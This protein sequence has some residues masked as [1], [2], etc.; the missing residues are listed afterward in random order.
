MAF[1]DTEYYATRLLN[2]FQG[3]VHIISTGEA[4]AESTDGINWR[5]KIRSG[6][7]KTP[8]TS[9]LHPGQSSCDF[10]YGVWSHAEGLKRVPV[11]P[12][13]YQEHVEQAVTDLLAQLATAAEKL[14]FPFRDIVECWMMDTTGK[15]PIVLLASQPAGEA[16]PASQKLNWTPTISSDTSCL[17]RSNADKLL[18]AVQQRCNPLNQ[19]LWIERLT[20]GDGMILQDHLGKHK[21]R[22]ELIPASDFPCCTFSESWK[23]ISSN[24]LATNY[25]H[26]LAPLLLMIPLPTNRR[27]ELEIS[28]QQRPLVVHRYYRLYPEVTDETLLKKILVEAVMRKSAV[29]T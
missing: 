14:P 5:I 17:G 16:I 10:D 9:L 22:N 27:R 29:T 24:R 2:P 13:L 4:R 28:S 11:H 7:Y 23:D 8:W 21:R 12:S 1:I 18:L 15:Q 26:W 3:A 19:V 6:I 25:I 20:G